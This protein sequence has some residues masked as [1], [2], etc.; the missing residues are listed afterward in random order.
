MG[1]LDHARLAALGVT[2]DNHGKMPG[3][4]LHY[5]ERNW[6]LLVEAVTSYGPVDAKRHAELA[7]LFGGSS[8]GLVDVTTFPNRSVMARY[9]LEIAR[10]TEV[11]VA[12]APTHMIH[13]NGVRFFGPDVTG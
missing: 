2:V 5:V 8:A 11:W 12:N 4:A 1:H 10:E 9:L 7:A 13:L 6:L 3:V